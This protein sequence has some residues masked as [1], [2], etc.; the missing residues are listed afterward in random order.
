MIDAFWMN[1]GWWK[2]PWCWMTHHA[3]GQTG[4]FIQM[5]DVTP[6]RAFIGCRC[7]RCGKVIEAIALNSRPR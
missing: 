7:R 6:V 1:S 2:R 5:Y 3:Y 4:P